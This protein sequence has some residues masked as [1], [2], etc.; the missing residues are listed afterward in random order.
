[1]REQGT[2]ERHHAPLVLYDGEC[3]LCTR[4]S[5]LLGRITPRGAWEF[6]PLQSPALRGILPAELTPERL[7]AQMYVLEPGGRAYGGAA[8]VARVLRTVPL[9]GV[10]AHLYD[11]PLVRPLADRLY[12]WLARR[13][14][15]LFGRRP[16]CGDDTCRLAER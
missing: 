6:V 13:R 14:Y 7:R 15:R 4:Q 5:A 10:L 11:L 2:F 9:V 3:L 16:A 12:A 1:M 8:A